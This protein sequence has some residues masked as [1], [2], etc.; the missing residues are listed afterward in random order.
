MRSHLRKRAHAGVAG[1]FESA[2]ECVV[3]R[4]MRLAAFLYP[5]GYHVAAWRLP[6]V[7]ADAG[8]NFPHYIELAAIAEN[9][10]FDFLFLPDVLGVKGDDLE[11]LSHSAIRYVSQFE[12]MTLLGALAATTSRIGLVATAS[13]TYDE[14]FHIARRFASLDHLSGGRAGWNLVVSRYAEEAANF[15]G[16]APLSHGERYARAEEAADV[17][18]KLWDSWAPDAFVRDKSAG[19]FF[20]PSKVRPTAYRGEHFSVAGP[21]TLPRSPQGR[22]IVVQAGSSGPGRQLAARVADVVFTAQKSIDEAVAFREDLHAR[23][24]ALGR[25]ES[26]LPLVLVGIMPFVGSTADEAMAKLDALQ[27]LIDPVV[28]LSLLGTELGGVNLT[29]VDVDGPLPEIPETEG[30]QSRRDLLLRSAHGRGATVRDLYRDVAAN[31]GHLQVVGTPTTIADELQSWT[32][33]SA[34]DGFIVMA[35]SFPGGLADFAT[36]V[37]PELVKRGLFRNEYESEHLR[38]HLGLG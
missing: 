26:E 15:H 38:D 20:D 7:P 17:V 1:A 11:V 23:S 27:N 37:V 19:V 16:D 22:P 35:P 10:C 36:A 5:T 6:D 28:G 2:R 24:R 4:K 9:A 13:T 25:Q 14:P 21:L 18:L 33:A 29:G 12:P 8:V 31:R 30:G 3:A 32:H 34:C